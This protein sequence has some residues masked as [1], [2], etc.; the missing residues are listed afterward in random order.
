MK[1]SKLRIRQ[2]IK[3]VLLKEIAG[4]TGTS[5]SSPKRNPFSG[6][7]LEVPG[8]S[9]KLSKKSDKSNVNTDSVS[10]SSLPEK[11]RKPSSKKNLKIKDKAGIISR[12]EDNYIRGGESEQTKT[13]DWGKKELLK[14][15]RYFND[16]VFPWS[17][18]ENNKSDIIV[19]E[20][21]ATKIQKEP[22]ASDSVGWNY[23]NGFLKGDK[24]TKKT[25]KVSGKQGTF[26]IANVYKEMLSSAES[27]NM[28]LPL[29]SMSY[30]DEMDLRAKLYS[31][32]K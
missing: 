21:Y 6:L 14:T 20:N 16:V 26:P 19:D 10:S 5:G 9:G 15:A 3:E 28:T 30:K 22:L 17:V 2:L 31:N 11:N 8:V 7:D 29:E 12:E 25:M 32:R 24:L 23:H 18:D 4:E 13:I 1:I 27:L